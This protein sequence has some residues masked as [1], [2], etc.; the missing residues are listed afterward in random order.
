MNSQKQYTHE[1][2]ILNDSFDKTDVIIKVIYEAGFFDPKKIYHKM[3]IV[4]NWRGQYIHVYENIQ[5]DG[6][7]IPVVFYLPNDV[8]I[9][10]SNHEYIGNIMI[11]EIAASGGGRRRYD[12]IKP[13]YKQSNRRHVCRDGV[14]RVIYVKDDKSYVKQKN[15]AGRFTYRRIRP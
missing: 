6:T 10:D 15:N 7:Y 8:S 1:I 9:F 13:V 14:S 5:N 12:A 2:D 11:R 4:D 3:K